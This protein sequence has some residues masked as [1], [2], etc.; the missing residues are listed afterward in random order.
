[1]ALGYFLLGAGFALN[2]FATRLPFLFLAM[3]VFTVGEMISS[4]VNGAYMAR[5]APARLR[6]RYMGVLSLSWCFS[7]IV[8]PPVG[9][10]LLAG[11]HRLGWLLCGVLGLLAAVLA[12]RSEPPEEEPAPPRA[13]IA[14]VTVLD[15]LAPP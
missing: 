8:G 6:G 2:A 3:T 5:L 14:P 7:S 12:L 1:M 4:P 15:A 10:R 11:G 13:K 9:M